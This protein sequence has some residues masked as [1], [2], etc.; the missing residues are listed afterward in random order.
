MSLVAVVHLGRAGALGNARRIETWTGLC[1]AA[2][3]R[4]TEVDLSQFPRRLPEAG[5]LRSSAS[6]ETVPESLMWSSRGLKDRL[7]ELQPGTVVFVTARTFDATVTP[8]GSTLVLDYVDLLSENY[9]A[10][11]T[12]HASWARRVAFAALVAPMRRFEARV[13]PRV[14]W[15]VAA[16]R[17][18]AAQMGAVWLP[19]VLQSLP[20]CAPTQADHDVVFHG[21]LSYEP[22]IEA[23]EAF[24]PIWF[25]A[26]SR[27][28]EIRMLVAGAAPPS[29]VRRLVDGTPGWTLE[30][31]FKDLCSLLGRARLGVAPMVSATG[32]QN[33]VLECAAHGLPLLMSP[34]VARGLDAAFPA[35][36]CRTEQEWVETVLDLLA[37]PA[38]RR[39]LAHRAR[40]H[41]ADH[42]F[43]EHQ[44]AGL[45][46][47]LGGGPARS[48]SDPPPRP[49]LP[50]T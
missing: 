7:A 50:R 37:Q 43:A 6:G 16:G 14:A 44:T 4:S 13:D 20:T 5:K 39:Q 38:R 8:S 15:R 32:F 49:D 18:E 3:L 47:L 1:R 9:R 22:N 42:Y 35:L 28:P 19:N 27:R 24:R 45:K 17:E 25:A 10:R 11:S 46:T 2:G 12:R 29:R 21:T 33:K 40:A 48:C 31:D 23:L 34:A 26:R 30:S 41:V 36:T